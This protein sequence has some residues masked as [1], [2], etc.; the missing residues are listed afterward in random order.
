MGESHGPSHTVTNITGFHYLVLQFAPKGGTVG[1]EVKAVI[2][3]VMSELE[4]VVFG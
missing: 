1:N 3:L 4:K 2:Q